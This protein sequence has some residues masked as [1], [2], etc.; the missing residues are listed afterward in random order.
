VCNVLVNY[1]WS[2]AALDDAGLHCLT[3]A[4]ITLRQLPAPQRTAWASLFEYYVFGDKDK[5]VAHIPAARRGVL[6][7]L[8][9]ESI[10]ARRAELAER[11]KA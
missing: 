1:W 2:P 10:R 8:D 5:T 6:G 9:A 7:P 4:L 11:L 3:H